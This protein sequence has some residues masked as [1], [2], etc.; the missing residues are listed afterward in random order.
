MDIQAIKGGNS[1]ACRVKAVVLQVCS[2]PVYKVCPTEKC[3]KKLIDT[4]TIEMK[5]DECQQTFNHCKYRYKT[6]I[7]VSDPSGEAW[8]TLWDEKAEQ[9]FS[10]KAEDIHE[11]IISD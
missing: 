1:E 2:K 5:C 11:L 8:I 7:K 6:D 9:L 3:G 4:Q 10:S